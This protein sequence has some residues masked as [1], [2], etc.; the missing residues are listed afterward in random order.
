M[1]VVLLP[2][3]LFHDHEPARG[4][5]VD[6][7]PPDLTHFSLLFPPYFYPL[8]TGERVRE[9]L[10]TNYSAFCWSPKELYDGLNGRHEL[11]D[12]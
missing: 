5:V 8:P 12:H 4:L 7:R 6:S 2:A 11:P 9:D 1:E 10:F 3:L